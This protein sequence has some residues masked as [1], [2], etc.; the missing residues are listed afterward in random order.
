MLRPALDWVVLFAGYLLLSGDAGASESGL[1]A[2]VAVAAAGLAALLRSH[3]ERRLRLPV[4]VVGHVAARSFA[5]VPGDV[6]RVGRVLLRAILHRPTGAIGSLVREA[7]PGEDGDAKAGAR[8]VTMLGRSLPPDSYV[9][10]REGGTQV[11]HALA[12]EASE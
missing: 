2:G 3:A 1:G 12:T 5:A 11:L 8:A 4:R 10:R 9:V 6:L 7:L